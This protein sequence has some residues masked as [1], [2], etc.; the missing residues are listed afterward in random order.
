MSLKLL[1]IIAIVIGLIFAYY[2]CR[3]QKI[4]II[5]ACF[6]FGYSLAGEIF[7]SLIADT[8]ILFLVEA[9]VGCICA[10]IGL[11]IEKL[12]IF[13]GVAY[14]AYSAIGAYLPSISNDLIRLMIQ[15]GIALIIG[16]FS[17]MFIKEIFIIAS[18]IYGAGLIQQYLPNLFTIPTL[19]LT[20]ITVLIAITG[21][22]FQ[23][24]SN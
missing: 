5:L 21:M 7:P 3:V 6:G 1:A 24:K 22:I 19:V 13:L 9:L 15:A 11:K 12:A 20:I 17:T 16:A 14:L 18:A 8:K 23:F 10:L 2:G 4:L